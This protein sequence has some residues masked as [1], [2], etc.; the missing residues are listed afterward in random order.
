[1]VNVINLNIDVKSTEKVFTEVVY[2]I[3]DVTY[4]SHV[5]SFHA[6]LITY[7]I[8]KIQI[9]YL[10]VESLYIKTYFVSIWIHRIS[11]IS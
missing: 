10:H 7:L 9:D 4:A 2:F 11:G 8:N 6:N 1:M 5:V 3:I